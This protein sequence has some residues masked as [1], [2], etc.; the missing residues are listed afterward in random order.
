M[1]KLILT[2]L[3]VSFLFTSCISKK[4][5]A[6]LE[7]TNKQNKDLLNSATLKLNAC[8]EDKSNSEKYASHEFRT[9][10]IFRASDLMVDSLTN[11]L[12]R[13]RKKRKAS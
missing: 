11:L 8:I 6:A 1:K 2:I 3:T 12:D 7:S 9:N 5:Y 4:D 13:E 10:E